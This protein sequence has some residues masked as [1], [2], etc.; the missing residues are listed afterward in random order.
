VALASASGVGVGLHQTSG[1][2]AP[3]TAAA[4]CGGTERWPVKVGADPSVKAVNTATQV[5]SIAALNQI[6]PTELD[7]PGGRMAPEKQVY[8]ISSA[9]IAFF[10]HEDDG[11]YHVVL[12]D[13]ASAPYA[14][15][16]EPG[17]G[18][19][20]VVEIPDPN[21]FAGKQGGPT[22]SR[23]A[24]EIGDVRAQF[25]AETRN[26][27]GAHLKQRIQVAVTGVGFFD[28]YHGQTGHSVVQTMSDGH[29][30]VIELHPVTAITFANSTVE[31]D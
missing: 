1:T 20:V 23:F 9:Y 26:L 27:D 25:E 11:D 24:Q 30:K 8:A 5:T 16:K 6:A 22:N 31:P 29:Q 2:P 19:S 21:C 14:P 18:H 7:Q 15:G 4:A 13:S 28:F 3:T 12:T 10:K 17:T